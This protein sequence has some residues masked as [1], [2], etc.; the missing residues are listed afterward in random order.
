MNYDI[1]KYKT[2]ANYENEFINDELEQRFIKRYAVLESNIWL[3]KNIKNL[4]IEKENSENKILWNVVGYLNLL[5]FDLASVGYSLIFEKKRWQKIYFARQVVLLIYEALEDI[6]EIL[7]KSYKSLFIDVP[8][9][10]DFILNLNLY[11]TDL[12][13]F[14]KLYRE[15]LLHIRVNV[16][17]HRDKD[18]NMQLEI[19]EEIDPYE[20]IKLMID[21]E[22][23]LRNI[24]DHLQ[25]LVVKMVTPIN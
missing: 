3:I 17:A 16:C 10:S 1:L 23:I 9:S 21:F 7:G 19:I 11:K 6:P 20:I 12:Q 8:R 15:Y 25:K 13:E 18:I 4:A 22:K 2:D 5:A 24:T 14:K